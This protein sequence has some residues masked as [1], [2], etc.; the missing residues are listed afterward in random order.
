M[1]EKVQHDVLAQFA[2][3][4]EAYCRLLETHT[5]LSDEV[6]TEQCA[7]SLATLYRDALALPESHSLPKLN[8]DCT[9]AHAAYEADYSNPPV[10][11]L[12]TKRFAAHNVDRHWLYTD[13]FDPESS[14]TTRVSNDLDEIYTSLRKGLALYHLGTDCALLY[15]AFEWQFGWFSHWGSH[16]AQALP[17][18]HQIII[19]DQHAQLRA[20]TQAQERAGG[21]DAGAD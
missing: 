11:A 13:P 1:I 5:H 9:E 3:S 2:D 21:D 7:A 14:L 17:V 6:F 10:H 20:T 15:A 4:A 12:L 19:D 18:L 8:P 16:L